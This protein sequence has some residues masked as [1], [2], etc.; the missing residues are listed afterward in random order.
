MDHPDPQ[1][2]MD[3]LTS[4]WSE[5]VFYEFRLERRLLAIA[6][7]DYLIDALS[8]VYTFFDPQYAK[9]SLGRL[10]ILYEI[11]EAKERGLKW[12]YL[13]YW[14]SGCR[15]MQY[16]NEYQPLEYLSGSRWIRQPFASNRPLRQNDFLAN[17]GE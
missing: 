13:G 6:V 7:V 8:A 4:S 12:L 1:H 3:F 9:R 16:K 5:T 14:V 15:K 11:K 2:F 17:R 10:A